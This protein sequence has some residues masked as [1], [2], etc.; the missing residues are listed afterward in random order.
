MKLISFIF[1]FVMS[2]GA[3]EFSMGFRS[4]DNYITTSFTSI[5]FDEV[6]T[7]RLTYPNNGKIYKIEFDFWV[8]DLYVGLGGIV[9]D[10][11]RDGTNIDMDY[12]KRYLLISS[13]A[14]NE[15]DLSQMNVNLGYRFG[16]LT[17]FASLENA[18]YD[19]RMTQLRFT[20]YGNFIYYGKLLEVDGLDSRF[21]F[22]Y[23]L[24]GCGFKHFRELNDYVLI[25]L[26][27]GYYFLNS[28]QAKGYWNLRNLHFTQSFYKPHLLKGNIS[29]GVKYKHL[30][31]AGGFGVS[32]LSAN[33]ENTY[34]NAGGVRYE[35][36][37]PIKLRSF[38]YSTN[39]E[40]GLII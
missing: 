28:F 15:L 40:F 14:S 3:D 7:S 5:I 8:N 6:W 39:I 21:G 25:N 12:E 26:E 16:D 9:S 18:N 17:L 22:D 38:M 27:G 34:W 33:G 32:Y 10:R 36:K 1:F 24:I 37:W 35:R 2:V 20:T 11:L 4:T 13:R 30:Y 29:L 31:I 19:Y 23:N